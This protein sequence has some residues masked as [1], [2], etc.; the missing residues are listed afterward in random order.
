MCACRSEEQIDKI[1]QRFQ[2][3]G[4][5]ALRG[6]AL[7][8]VLAK[9]IS[10]FDAAHHALSEEGS[11]EWKLAFDRVS[12]FNLAPII[13]LLIL[14]ICPVIFYAY[15]FLP[16]WECYDFTAAATHEVGHVLGLTHPDSGAKE[17]LNFWYRRSLSETGSGHLDFKVNCTHPWE[18]V[19]EW[20]NTTSRMNARADANQPGAQDARALYVASQSDDG[21]IGV[22]AWK[23]IMA[24]F[25]FNNPSTCIFQD[26]LDAL[27]VRGK[28]F[29]RSSTTSSS[30]PHLYL[31]PYPL[32]TYPPP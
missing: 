10:E 30:L 19:E 29:Y 12:R 32:Y 9:V 6:E 24:T 13:F 11:I 25:T 7:E 2:T 14:I 3:K 31:P 1:E 17:G 8:K 4:G 15:I 23:T 22:P 20:P 26:D 5:A 18:M 27:N 16:C 21:A 28:L